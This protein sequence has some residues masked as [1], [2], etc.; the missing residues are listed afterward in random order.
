MED[1]KTKIQLQTKV[2][3][4]GGPRDG[5]VVHIDY[6][7]PKVLEEGGHYKLLPIFKDM[8]LAEFRKLYVWCPNHKVVRYGSFLWKVASK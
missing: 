4:Y 8:S 1:K 7:A 3:Y 2:N 5:Q 6:A